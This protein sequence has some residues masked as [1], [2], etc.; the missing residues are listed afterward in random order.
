MSKT[1]ENGLGLV[2]SGIYYAWYTHDFYLV[3]PY[4]VDFK[5]PGELRNP[6]SKTVLSKCSF[7]WNNEPVNIW[8]D[9]KAQM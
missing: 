8:N 1:C 2:N 5:A 7:I 3:L 6:L 9:H 4:A